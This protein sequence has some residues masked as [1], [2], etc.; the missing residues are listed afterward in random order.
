MLKGYFRRG[1][2]FFF[3]FKTFYF[4]EE[5]FD[6]IL[7]RKRCPFCVAPYPVL[8]CVGFESWQCPKCEAEFCLDVNQIVLFLFA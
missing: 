8:K 4:R 2:S 6:W 3:H 7:K 5:I 1:M